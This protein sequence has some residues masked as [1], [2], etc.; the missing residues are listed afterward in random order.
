VLPEILWLEVDEGVPGE[1]PA[2]LPVV[3]PEV[4]E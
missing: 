3:D 1:N 2:D 4:G